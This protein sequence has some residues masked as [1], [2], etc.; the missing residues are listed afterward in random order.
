MLLNSQYLDNIV[1]PDELSMRS[2][3]ANYNNFK[4][5]TVNPQNNNFR[6]SNVNT[7]NYNIRNSAGFAPSVSIVK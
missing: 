4:T 1:Y 6:A 7:Q 3:V 2:S 5:S